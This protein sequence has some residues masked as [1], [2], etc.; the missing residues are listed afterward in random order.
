MKIVVMSQSR[1]EEYART[2]NSETS[3]LISIT[4][5]HGKQAEVYMNNENKILNILFLRFDDTDRRDTYLGISHIDAR[6]IINF[7]RDNVSDKD[8][9]KVIVNCEAG[10]SRSAGV[11]AAL[12]KYFNNDDTPIFDNPMYTPNMLCYRTVIDAAYYMDYK[13]K[14]ARMREGLG[15]A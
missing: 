12:M 15:N 4:S 5:H 7:I 8:F 3:I 14:R 6:K 2:S 9:D 1:I 13:E 10:Q 11:A